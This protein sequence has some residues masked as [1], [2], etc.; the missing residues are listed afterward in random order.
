MYTLYIG[1]KNYSSWSL[2]P[3]ILMREL[4]I[5]FTEILVPFNEPGFPAFTSFSPTAKVPVLHDGSERVWETLS[6][7]EYL[8]ERHEGVWPKDAKARAWARS[9]ASEMHAGFGTLRNV[10]SM[11]VG[12]RITLHEV[13]PALQKD[14]DR[15]GALWSEGLQRF[16]GPFLAGPTFTAVD[17]FYAP[18]VFRIQTYGLAL[19]KPA[20]D[21]VK[22]ILDLKG[23]KDWYAAGLAE[24]WRDLP[25][26]AETPT[27]GK[28]TADFRT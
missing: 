17:A 27:F 4:G 28:I 5:P 23:M 26:E 1:N 10:C 13:T 3:W 14:V 19:P 25:H 16:G 20:A 7:C 22:R 18:V 11:S 8:A 12:L 15:I 2:R 21:Y 6:I 24:K 9:A